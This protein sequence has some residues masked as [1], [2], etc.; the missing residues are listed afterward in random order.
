MTETWDVAGRIILSGTN[1]KTIERTVGLRLQRRHVLRTQMPNAGAIG[2]FARIGFR[3]LKVA[4]P[5]A[6]VR[7][8]LEILSGE[9]PADRPVS[10]RQHLVRDAGIDQRLGANDRSGA[11]G[12]IHDD[13][14]LGIR[15]DTARTQH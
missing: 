12:A 9:R 7:A 2:N 15:R 3:A 10:Q 14:R 6:P 11:T 4:D 13:R 1:V 8:M 5:A